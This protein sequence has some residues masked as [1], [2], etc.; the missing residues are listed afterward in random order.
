[1]SRRSVVPAV[2][3][4]AVVGAWAPTASAQPLFHYERDW[5][6][7]LGGKMYGVRDVVQ[8]P[9]GLRWPQV[10][11]AGHSFSPANRVADRAAVALVPGAA[12]VLA[13]R[14][15]TRLLNPG[16]ARSADGTAR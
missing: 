14:E 8:E 1:M 3:A 6:A 13:V 5:T 7:T 4:L 9:N 11:V 15:V 2:A 12:A 16:R 10:W